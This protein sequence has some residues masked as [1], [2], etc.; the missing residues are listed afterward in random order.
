[1]KNRSAVQVILLTIVT[2]GIYGLIWI[3]QTKREMVTLGAQIP[4]SWLL[5]IPIAN[6][7]YL[8]KYCMGVE[9]VS[10]G[11]KQGLMLLL[12]WLLVPGGVLISM[13]IIQEA[14]NK[15]SATQNHNSESI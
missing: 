2:L 11:E 1:M 13:Y 14:F 5:I 12:V 8:Y 7:I 15:V 6:L 4:T 9:F 10:K 3:V